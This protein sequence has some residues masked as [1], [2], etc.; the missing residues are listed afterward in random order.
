[1]NNLSTIKAAIKGLKAADEYHRKVMLD[2]LDEDPS[3]KEFYSEA[4]LGR[5]NPGAQKF[6]EN[7]S[8]YIT[9]TNPSTQGPRR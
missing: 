9:H 5:I 6:A 7:L 1:M 2:L 8:V 4:L 3:F